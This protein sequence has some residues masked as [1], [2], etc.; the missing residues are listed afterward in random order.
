MK[1]VV[2]SILTT[3]ANLLLSQGYTID[4]GD[5]SMKNLSTAST[6]CLPAISGKNREIYWH[7]YDI[8]CLFFTLQKVNVC[9]HAKSL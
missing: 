2:N 7:T 8:Y 6:H 9:M 4:G 1:V 5:L 3:E